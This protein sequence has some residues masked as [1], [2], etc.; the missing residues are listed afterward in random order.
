MNS[1]K[2]LL[3]HGGDTGSI[4]VR[5]AKAIN[6]LQEIPFH[7]AAITSTELVCVVRF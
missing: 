4:P 3:F 1:Y 7:G 6:H 5:D 2:S